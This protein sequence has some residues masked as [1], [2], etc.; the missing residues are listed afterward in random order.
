MVS[1]FV[2]YFERL[3]YFHLKLMP[4]YLINYH[5]KLVD[6]TAKKNK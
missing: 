2:D 1:N 6:N 5:L 3:K 4:K